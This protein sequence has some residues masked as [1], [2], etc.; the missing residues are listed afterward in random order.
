MPRSH[1][2]RCVSRLGIGAWAIGGGGW[3]FA[4]GPQDD[5]ES[6]AAI[7]K[8]LD[9][10]MNWIDTGRIYV[11]TRE[12]DARAGDFSKTATILQFY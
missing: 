3:R 12:R 8:A 7:H 9:A 5:N 6:V 1:E 10:G 4:W 2:I 11:F